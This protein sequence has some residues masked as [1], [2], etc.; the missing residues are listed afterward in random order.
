MQLIKVQK[1]QPPNITGLSLVLFLFLSLLSMMAA[2]EVSRSSDDL[3]SSVIVS[4]H[5][6]SGP[7][8]DAEADEFTL[9]FRERRLTRSAFEP[10]DTAGPVSQPAASIPRPAVK[11]RGPPAQG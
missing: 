4:V 7:S 10:S 8:A 9:Y 5:E 11:A 6:L 1:E 2:Y 3:R